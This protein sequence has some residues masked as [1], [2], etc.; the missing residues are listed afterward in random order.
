MKFIHL[1]VVRTARTFGLIHGLRT[2]RVP[3]GRQTR[4]AVAVRVLGRWRVVR[5]PQSNNAHLMVADRNAARALLFPQLGDVRSF[6]D[7][8]GF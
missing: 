6:L 1:P 3:V 2:M 4:W 5:Q 8:Q 7:R